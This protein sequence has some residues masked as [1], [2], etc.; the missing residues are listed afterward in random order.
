[1]LQHPAVV[2]MTKKKFLKS[3]LT[4]HS[5]DI[6]RFKICLIVLASSFIGVLAMKRRIRRKRAAQALAS[7]SSYE[8]EVTNNH[9]V[10]RNM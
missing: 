10:Q 6:Y 8:P 9:N 7:S 3:L 5:S 4:E 1:M 2:L